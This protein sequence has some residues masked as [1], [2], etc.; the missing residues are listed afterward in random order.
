M[1]MRSYAL[2][3]GL[4]LGG[5]SLI[6]S[7]ASTAQVAYQISLNT[8][9][10]QTATTGPYM[11]DFQFTDGSGIGDANNTVGL[12]NILFGTAGSAS[13]SPLLTGGAS[14]SLSSGFTLTDSSF[15]NEAMQGFTPGDQLSFTLSLSANVD[16][17]G[18]PDE[19]SLGLLDN[20]GNEIPTTGPAD[21]LLAV[22]IDS[23]DPIVQTY[24]ADAGR[25]NIGLRAPTVISV[26]EPSP[27]AF[28]ATLAGMCSLWGIGSCLRGRMVLPSVQKRPQSAYS[29]LKPVHRIAG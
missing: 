11:L 1:T 21:A 14:G 6:S 12:S 9:A 29:H 3:I 26:P 13:G 7:S 25:T 8:S 16:A 23:P 2:S 10:L 28:L 20:S 18:V 19:F 4:I 5:L 15:F 24:G 22:D 17:G 27:L